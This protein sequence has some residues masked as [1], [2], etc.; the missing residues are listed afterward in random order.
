MKNLLSLLLFLVLG[1]AQ[2]QEARTLMGQEATFTSHGFGGFA[3][4]MTA[5][6]G[7]LIPSFGGFGAGLYNER[8]ILGGG[9]YNLRGT[10]PDGDVELGY[11]GVMLGYIL[12]PERPLHLH[13][14]LLLGGGGIHPE[15][16]ESRA[17]MV[18][19]PLLEAEL[20]VSRYFRLG[21]GGGYRLLVGQTPDAGVS[22]QD[23]SGFFGGLSFRF[24]PFGGW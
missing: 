6:D 8:L 11:G 3:L 10:T 20:N 23:L 2:A 12:A 14:S 24:G 15:T 18:L 5:L 1:T 7:A 13:T 4:R 9:G 21:I 19:E 16:G 17:V 22:P